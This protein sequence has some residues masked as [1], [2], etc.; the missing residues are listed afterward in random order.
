MLV[1][2]REGNDGRYVSHDLG[3]APQRLHCRVMVAPGNVMGGRVVILRGLDAQGV[4]TFRVDLSAPERQVIFGLATGQE[5]YGNYPAGLTWQCVEVGVDRTAGWAKLWVNG[6]EVGAV[7][8]SLAGLATRV[9]QLGGMFKETATTGSL[10]LD[11]WVISQDYIGPV[12]IGPR[13]EY[14]EDPARWLVVYNAALAEG[15]LWAEAYRRARGV[16]YA[17]LCGLNLPSQETI[18]SSEY[19]SLK[20]AIDGYL[21]RNGLSGQVMGILLGYGVPGYVSFGLILEAVPALLVSTD[22]WRGMMYNPVFSGTAEVRPVRE[23]LGGLRLTARLDGPSLEAAV[24]LI[25]RADRCIA[26][27]V[28]DGSDAWVYLVPPAQSDPYTQGIIQDICQWAESRFAQRVRLPIRLIE[29]GVSGGE[30]EGISG[31]GFF[32][33]W[34]EEDPEREFFGLPTGWR[35]FGGQLNCDRAT[36]PTLRL[37]EPVGWVG[38]ALAGGYAAVAGSCREFSASAVPRIRPFFEALEKGWT[39]AEAWFLSLPILR[40]A[41]YLVGDPLLRVKMPREGWDVLGPVER[42]EELKVSEPARMVRREVRSVLL[43]ES[44]RPDVGRTGL[45]VVRQRDRKGRSEA[46]LAMVR[47]CQVEGRVVESLPA[48]IW[49][50]HAGWP[51]N[52][53][54]ER[55]KAVLWWERAWPELAG[56]EVN[57]LIDRGSGEGESAWEGKLKQGQKQV[58]GE[59]ER[60]RER[61]RLAWRVR[62]GAGWSWQSAWS[63]WVVGEGPEQQEL[64]AEVV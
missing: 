43:P 1:L 28:G 36:G 45:Y 40:E 64:V 2:L 60:G 3:T 32:W 48:P 35:V 46:G 26:E 63:A 19:A 14:A 62:S 61:I 6:L 5:I 29:S 4:E 54:G 9:L 38:R 30:L 13:S 25:E 39:L 41:I 27:A 34:L 20:G 10:G 53:E 18:N 49:P 16:P 37:E 47:V 22:S 7:N 11:E 44:L 24:A 57:L 50:D 21:E 15:A 23:N 33:G 56:A 31:D 12:V 52:V 58:V 59:V 8:G 42:L 51:V 17:N 55:L